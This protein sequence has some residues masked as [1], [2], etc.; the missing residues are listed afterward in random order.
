MFSFDNIVA[1]IVRYNSGRKLIENQLRHMAVMTDVP[2]NFLKE[3]QDK[4]IYKVYFEVKQNESGT[5]VRQIDDTK[6]PEIIQAQLSIIEPFKVPS[7]KVIPAK[8]KPRKKR[9]KENFERTNK[10]LKQPE[11]KKEN[12]IS[13]EIKKEKQTFNLDEILEKIGRLG[14]HKITK[15]ERSFLDS[16]SSDNSF[17]NEL[18]FINPRKRNKKD[19]ELNDR[20]ASSWTKMKKKTKGWRIPEIDELE[21]LYH[22]LHKKGLGNFEDKIYWS[23]TKFTID[24][25]WY[26]DFKN[27]R[28]GTMNISLTAN[29]R[30]I[31]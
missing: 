30:Y 31:K 26:F 10:P 28:D 22:Q 24:S 27:G 25:A 16:L 15:A 9:P 4:G 11:Q 12:K 6:M 21:A 20:E 13:K 8:R 7:E 14:L 5:E 19:V 3:A 23:A 2:Y 18:T 1:I 17:K 29:V